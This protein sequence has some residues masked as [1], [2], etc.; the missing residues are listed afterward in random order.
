MNEWTHGVIS[1]HILVLSLVEKSLRVKIWSCG[2]HCKLGKEEDTGICQK[3]TQF[4]PSYE[5]GGDV[6]ERQLCL[7]VQKLLV[8]RV[9]IWQNLFWRVN[10]SKLPLYGI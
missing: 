6:P 9:N 8:P 2:C 5:G 7:L 1:S 10:T 3:E 4:L